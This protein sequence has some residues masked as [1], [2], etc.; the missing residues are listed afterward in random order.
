MLKILYEDKDI[1]VVWKPVGMESQSSRGFGADMVSEIRK[2]IHKFSTKS[3]EPYVG[4]IHRLDKPVSG[5]MVY[6]KTKKAAG[7]LSAQVSAGKM[8]KKYLAVV[9]GQPVDSVD[10]Y[11]DYLLKDE[12]SNTSK[13]VDKGINGGKLAELFFRPVETREIEPYGILT[14][15]EIELLTGRH[16]QIRV[17][18]AGH[19]MPLWGDNRYNPKFRD[20]PGSYR[21]E[22]V[23]LAAWHLEFTHPEMGKKLTFEAFPEQEIFKKFPLFSKA[24]EE[25]KLL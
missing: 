13:I 7:T 19:G 3:G 12:K 15:A 10:K 20:Q 1:I 5:V 9:C 25:G 22:N 11:V 2:H 18:M 4:V 6:A 8:T 21:R 17:Q 14:L 24:K 16:H 23:A